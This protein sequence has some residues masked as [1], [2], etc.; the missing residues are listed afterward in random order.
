MTIFIQEFKG[1]YIKVAFPEMYFLDLWHI[2]AML[3]NMPWRN[4]EYYFEFVVQP[5]V[6]PYNVVFLKSDKLKNYED[7]GGL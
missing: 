2:V 3:T 6:P 7:Q 5:V 1:L 4:S